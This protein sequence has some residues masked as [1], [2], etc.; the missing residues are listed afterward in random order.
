[1]HQ[2][3]KAEEILMRYL[4][5]RH[6]NRQPEEISDSRENDTTYLEMLLGECYLCQGKYLKAEQVVLRYQ[7][8]L[9]GY[10]RLHFHERFR[11]FFSLTV[12]ARCYHLSGKFKDGLKYWTEAWSYCANELN[13]GKQQGKWS[14]ATIFPNIIQLSM[15]DCNYE[16]G[17]LPEFPDQRGR[18]EKLIKDTMTYWVP[19]LATYWLT[20][21]R[22]KLIAQEKMRVSV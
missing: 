21:V 4:G 15:L 2:T 3:D 17:N 12:L 18:S 13:V 22:D 9:Q 16:L 8:K 1:M 19:G 11:Y 7:K 10:S 14:E 20:W 6:N 5:L